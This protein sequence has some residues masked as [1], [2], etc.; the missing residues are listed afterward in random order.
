MLELLKKNFEDKGYS[1]LL[2]NNK[3]DVTHYLIQLL[4]NKSIGLGGSITIKQLDLYNQLSVHNT[5]YSHDIIHSYD[6]R[7]KACRSDIY[8]SSVN[9]VSL[10]G[11]IVNMDNTGNRVAGIS[12]GCE[13]VY[14]IIGRNKVCDSLESTIERVRH[15]AGPMNAKRLNRNTPCVVDGKYHNCLS[16]DRICRHLSIFLQRPLGCEYEILLVDDDLGY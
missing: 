12:F 5:V 3:E 1:V 6:E 16:K 9:G 15:V 2:F 4:F 10:N 13:K 8:I 14:L 11:E 7:L